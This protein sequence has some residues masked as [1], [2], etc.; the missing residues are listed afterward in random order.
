[1]TSP[2]TFHG[3]SPMHYC[4]PTMPPEGFENPSHDNPPPPP[5]S[6]PES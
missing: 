3:L 4:R 5:T 6:E 1:M 2:S